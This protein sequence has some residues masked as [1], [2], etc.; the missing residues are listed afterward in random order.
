MLWAACTTA[1][2]SFCRSGEITVNSKSYD[3]NSHLSYDD[4]RIDNKK[5]P[6]I[7]AIHLKVSKIDQGKKGVRGRTDDDLYPVLALLAYLAKRGSHPGPLFHWLNRTPLTR[8]AFVD[9]IQSVLTEANITAKEY[10]G[11]SFQIGAGTTAAVAGIDDL[12]M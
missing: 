3:P 12:Q 10:L 9:A 7:I 4:L 5:H 6:K 11:H 8:L 2:F 1:F